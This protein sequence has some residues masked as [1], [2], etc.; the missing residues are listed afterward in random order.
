MLNN[1]GMNT[2]NYDALLNGWSQQTVKPNVAL[3]A[4]GVSTTVLLNQLEIF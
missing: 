1:S 2:A 3:G 4:G